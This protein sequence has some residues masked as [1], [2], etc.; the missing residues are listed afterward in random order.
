MEDFS[1]LVSYQQSSGNLLYFDLS[2]YR[3]SKYVIMVFSDV[4]AQMELAKVKK[5]KEILEKNNIKFQT[6][7]TMYSH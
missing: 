5:D 7:S 3:R 4:S 1:A 2:A 6:L